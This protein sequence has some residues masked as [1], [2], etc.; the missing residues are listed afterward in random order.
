ML[1]QPQAVARLPPRL[2]LLALLLCSFGTVASAQQYEPPRSLRGFLLRGWDSG[3]F[4]IG[5]GLQY[6]LG[7][8]TEDD[9]YDIVEVAQHLDVQAVAIGAAHSVFLTTN[10]QAHAVGSNADGRLGVN[11]DAA[12]ESSVPYITRLDSRA[13]DAIPVVAVAAGGTF[14]LL[15]YEDGQ[16][17]YA[18]HA[19][20]GGCSAVSAGGACGG[21][22]ATA[23]FD[24]PAPVPVCGS[25][26]HI[27]AVAA[28]HSHSVYLDSNGTAWTAGDNTYGQ[29]GGVVLDDQSGQPWEAAG[30]GRIVAIAAGRF[31][32]FLI[33]E[34][35]RAYATGN[36]S[37]GELGDGTTVQVHQWV[38][39]ILPV[40]AVKAAASRIEHSSYWLTADG[41]VFASGMNGHGELGIGSYAD[42]SVPVELVALGGGVVDIAAGNQFALFLKANGDVWAAGR[43]D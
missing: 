24:Q 27:V 30:M 41:T 3:V 25:P 9:Y 28:G 23:A 26:Q 8:G 22:L 33:N 39:T 37:Y 7:T 10:G 17:Y 34:A 6:Q 36:N 42:Q 18:G 4:A 31:S 1:L 2:P 14:T 40:G 32:S 5:K 12:A 38:E 19:L 13:D 43:C 20:S 21:C 29:A 16:V 35:G 11:I 15:L